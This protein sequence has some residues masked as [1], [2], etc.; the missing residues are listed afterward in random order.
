MTPPFAANSRRIADSRGW[1][2]SLRSLV[3]VIALAIAVVRACLEPQN[4]SILSGK[5]IR[6]AEGAQA[7]R[8]S[9]NDASA[10]RGRVRTTGRKSAR[11]SL[12]AG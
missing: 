1:S 7:C 9:A 5:R 8:L 12:R 6:G 3:E 4:G 11:D 2:S 10:S